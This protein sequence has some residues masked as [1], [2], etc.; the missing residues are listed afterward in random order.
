[1]LNISNNKLAKTNFDINSCIDT[2]FKCSIELR[3]RLETFIND[4]IDTCSADETMCL[5]LN[6]ALTGKGY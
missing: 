5:L 2:T 3:D 4:H 1:M 6:E